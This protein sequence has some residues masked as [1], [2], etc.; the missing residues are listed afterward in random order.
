MV[1]APRDDD[2]ADGK[3]SPD[4]PIP[5]D[6]FEPGDGDS[7]GHAGANLDPRRAF[8]VL[9]IRTP[10]EEFE[11]YVRAR[12]DTLSRLGEPDKANLAAEALELG[13]RALARVTGTTLPEKPAP[14]H[15]EGPATEKGDR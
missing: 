1:D 8:E 9:E 2:A 7:D 13:R 6:S 15:V 12:I 5:G 10:L 14:S 3:P 11:A 4:T